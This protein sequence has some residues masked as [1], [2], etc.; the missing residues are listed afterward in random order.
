MIDPEHLK[1]LSLLGLSRNQAKIYL[2]LVAE[3]SLTT[4]DLVNRTEIPRT[5]IYS[6]L[7]D[8]EKSNWIYRVEGRPIMYYAKSPEDIY[9]KA[10]SGVIQ[11]LE[12]TKVHLKTKW[13]EREN[14]QTQTINVISGEV[15]L[16]QETLK[17]ISK[18]KET[19]VL[20][21]RF[22]FPNELIPILNA[23]EI[24]KIKG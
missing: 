7:Q 11:R 9:K 5:R 23:L 16:V 4:D 6:D 10:S 14:F 15:Y 20:T 2:T 21:L 1:T 18:A 8:M 3:Q 13:D 19:I 24:Q 12:E 17:D 22:I